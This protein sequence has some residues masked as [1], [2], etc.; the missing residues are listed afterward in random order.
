VRLDDMAVFHGN[1]HSPV[2]QEEKTLQD[3]ICDGTMPVEVPHYNIRRQRRCPP[4]SL[5]LLIPIYN[6]AVWTTSL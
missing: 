4:S 2:S 6:T 3:Q 5:F 1:D